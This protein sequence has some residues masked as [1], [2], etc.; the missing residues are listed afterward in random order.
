MK[1]KKRE[2]DTKRPKRPR[3]N[4]SERHRVISETLRLETADKYYP[5]QHVQKLE[6]LQ[7]SS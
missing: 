4:V 2:N 5:Y 7:F 3:R 1:R 6:K